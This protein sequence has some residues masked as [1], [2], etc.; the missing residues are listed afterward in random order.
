MSDAS[1]TISPAE[2]AG[3]ILR[4]LGPPGLAP[5]GVV[6]GPANDDQQQRGVISIMQAGLPTIELYTPVQWMRCQIRCLAGTLAE[7]D[8]ISFGVNAFLHG[9]GRTVG[10]MASTDHRYLVH[11]INVVA[12]PSMHYDSPETWET[13]L[14]AELMIGTDPLT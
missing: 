8:Q 11:M 6:T 3:D 5:A 10:R 9:R 1:D 7:A 14:F 2:L 12:G 4:R 13:L